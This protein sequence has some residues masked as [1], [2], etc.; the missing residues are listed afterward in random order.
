MLKIWLG[1]FQKGCI[2]NP[3]RYFDMHKKKEWFDREDVRKIIKHID[4]VDVLYGECLESPIFGGISPDRLSSGCKC[5]ILL[6]INPLCNV[7]AS[8]CGDN[9]AEFILDLAEKTDVIIT[10]HHAM[11]FPR[12]FEGVI[13]DNGIKVHTRR[14]FM[15]AYIDFKY[16]KYEGQI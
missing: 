7:Y 12:D 11:I 3:N 4:D 6:T 8:R 15:K 10:L 14:E 5:L 9:C 1:G 13:L 16:G 2:K